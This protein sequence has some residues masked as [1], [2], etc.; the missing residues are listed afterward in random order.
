MNDLQAAP[1][2]MRKRARESR[3]ERDT[4]RDRD[5]ETKTETERQRQRQKETGRRGGSR[6]SITCRCDAVGSGL[7]ISVEFPAS[8][9]GPLLNAYLLI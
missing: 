2:V 6:R 8:K 4:E 5:R 9:F 1:T 3:G 7:R